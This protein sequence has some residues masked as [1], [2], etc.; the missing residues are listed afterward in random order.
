MP[1]VVVYHH[2]HFYHSTADGKAM[3]M[4][5]GDKTAMPM[6]FGE[7]VPKKTKPEPT[8]SPEPTSSTSTS[9]P[10]TKKEWLAQRK[11]EMYDSYK[12]GQMFGNK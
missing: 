8:K 6:P 10:Y 3:P 1:Q 4:T 2:H 11:K 7:P 5:F 12:S 9:A